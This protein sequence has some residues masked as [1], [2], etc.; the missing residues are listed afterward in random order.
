MKF[1][2]IGFRNYV[3]T[4]KIISIT[5]IESAPLK[6]NRQNADNNNRF[7][8][9]TMGR[10]TKSLIF[11]NTHIIGSGVEPETLIKRLEKLKKSDK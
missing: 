10:K 6:R 3:N 7:V 1:L 5:G 4:D 2:D 11:T 8:D 9:A